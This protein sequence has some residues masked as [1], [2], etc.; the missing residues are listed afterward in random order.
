MKSAWGEG[1]VRPVNPSPRIVVSGGCVR[2]I[3]WRGGKGKVMKRDPFWVLIG[4]AYDG[5]QEGGEAV[6]MKAGSAVYYW[7]YQNIKRL[8]VCGEPDVRYRDSRVE[9]DESLPPAVMVL[10]AGGERCTLVL[11]V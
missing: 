11:T 10:S 4:D 1:V 2:S 7:F 5:L 6:T 9:L 3:E 8:E